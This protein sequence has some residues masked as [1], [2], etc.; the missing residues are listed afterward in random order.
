MVG[1]WMIWVFLAFWTQKTRCQSERWT[2]VTLPEKRYVWNGILPYC[3]N[4]CSMIVVHSIWFL[5]MHKDRGWCVTVVCIMQQN[6][7]LNTVT[8]WSSTSVSLS[9]ELNINHSLFLDLLFWWDCQK[10]RPFC[11]QNLIKNA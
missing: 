1:L 5:W 6:I 4:L 8:Q 11:A 3:L 10:L 9:N 2:R 7:V